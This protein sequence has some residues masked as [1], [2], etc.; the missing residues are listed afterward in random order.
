[1]KYADEPEL[2]AKS[3]IGSLTEIGKCYGIE[4]NVEKIR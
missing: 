3:M 1:M 2:L 4:M